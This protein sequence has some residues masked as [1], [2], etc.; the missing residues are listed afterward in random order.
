MTNNP[1]SKIHLKDKSIVLPQIELKY[2]GPDDD[3]KKPIQKDLVCC[4][5]GKKG[6]SIGSVKPDKEG[7]PQ[8]VCEECT[9]DEYQKLND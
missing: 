5:C 7:E 3:G 4:N 2:F 6:I 8:C 1:E 9:I